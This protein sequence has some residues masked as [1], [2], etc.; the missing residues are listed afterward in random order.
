MTFHI[1]R[2]AD[3]CPSYAGIVDYYYTH[4]GGERYGSDV[5]DLSF[6]RGNDGDREAQS[7]DFIIPF[8]P[9][10]PYLEEDIVSVLV[11]SRGV[12][13]DIELLPASQANIRTWDGQSKIEQNESEL[14]RVTGPITA[15][16]LTVD[17]QLH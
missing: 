4:E 14:F 2:R 10:N 8:F 3:V 1:Q 17:K 12:D 16:K 11:Q 7:G 5:I 9:H 13:I 6:L 15:T